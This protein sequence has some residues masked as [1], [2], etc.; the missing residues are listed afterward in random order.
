[1]G[2]NTSKVKTPRIP[3]DI[4][5]EILDHLAADSDSGSLRACALVS[6]SWV[7]SSRRHLFRTIP[8]SHRDMDKW[9]KA[10]PVPEESPAHYVRALRIW[11][12]GERCLPDKVFGRTSLFTNAEKVSLFAYG[13]VQRYETAP[14]CWWFPPTF[15]GGGVNLVQVR[16]LM[17][18]LPNLNDLSLSGTLVAVDSRELPGIG[19][20]LRGKFGGKLKLI[21]DFADVMNM[22]LEIPSGLR[23][24]EA[25]IH[26]K[27]ECLL[28]TIRLIEA[29]SETLV[30]L[31]YSVA[32]DGKSPL[33][34]SVRTTLTL[35]PFPDAEA[36]ERSFDFSKFPNLHTV[37]FGLWGFEGRPRWI[38]M[39]L[40]TLRPIT[41]PRL[42]ALQLDFFHLPDFDTPAETLV[43]N[44]GDDLRQVADEFT[45]IDRE[46]EGAVNLTVDRWQSFEVV[47]DT[48]N[49]RLH[50]R[51]ADGIA[52]P[53]LIP[54]H[55][56][57][58]RSFSSTA[59]ERC[60]RICGCFVF[61]LL[62]GVLPFLFC[63]YLSRIG[64]LSALPVGD[65]GT[66]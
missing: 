28:S 15:N 61:N 57:P 22:L 13:P 60:N 55:S 36:R 48:L 8:F 7:Q 11:T 18:Q 49:V 42:S 64:L 56:F 21:T 46:F 4:I 33:A 12:G 44:M 38:P 23:F 25:R 2:S 9:L 62:A 34:G 30:K 40:S 16:D 63:S 19:T 51:G 35:I 41:S 53:P 50:P 52:Y 6:K 27:N 5:E 66:R 59:L 54:F 17:A 45:R 58:H 24:I 32:F 47:L 1:M 10:F 26:C 3:Q 14:L 29:C 65:F 31:S 37:C 39:A 20:V 43:K